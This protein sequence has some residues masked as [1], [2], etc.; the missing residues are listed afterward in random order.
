MTLDAAL[1][2]RQTTASI[3]LLL[4]LDK[5]GSEPVWGTEQEPGGWDPDTI[6]AEVEDDFPAGRIDEEAFQRLLGAI[7]MVRDR[8]FLAEPFKFRVL[9]NLLGD[10]ESSFEP[11]F[12]DF[13][14]PE[15]IAWAVSEYTL[16]T[17]DEVR[18]ANPEVKE[19][20]SQILRRHGFAKP[21]AALV[22]ISRPWSDDE[23]AL[24]GQEAAN[25]QVALHLRVDAFVRQRLAALTGQ[26]KSLDLE[27]GAAREIAEQMEKTLKERKPA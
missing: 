27:G 3:L 1:A 2:S 16:L 6:R 20:V 11:D 12:V 19:M 7:A 18:T 14:E 10:D 26:L 21:P 5:Y 17:G 13:P 9:C 25:G 4:F 24:S 8:D 22:P 23:S 15:E